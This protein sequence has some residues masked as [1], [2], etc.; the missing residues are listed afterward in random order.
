LSTFTRVPVNPLKLA[1][2][3]WPRLP[4]SPG[5]AIY[6]NP[7]YI[8]CMTRKDKMKEGFVARTF[9]IPENIDDEL[10]MMAIKNHVRFSDM[11]IVAFKEH[12]SKV[13]DGSRK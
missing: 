5:T 2:T 9:H 13:K 1:E 11:A 12:I 4:D 6:G 7:A 8:I 3:R 10:R